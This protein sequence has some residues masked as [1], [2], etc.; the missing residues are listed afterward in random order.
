[1]SVDIS[2]VGCSGVDGTVDMIARL[3]AATPCT[4]KYADLVRVNGCQ[5]TAKGESHQAT[6]IL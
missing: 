1:M 6:V 5:E 2:G 4:T 3:V